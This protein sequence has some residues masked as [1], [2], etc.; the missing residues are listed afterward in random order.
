V[1]VNTPLVGVPK[2]GVTNVGLVLNTNKPVPVSSVIAAR[3][4]ALDG[5]FKKACTLA[6]K[7][8]SALI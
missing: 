4:F 5:V 6:A 1:L 2:I 8:V 3:K 7:T